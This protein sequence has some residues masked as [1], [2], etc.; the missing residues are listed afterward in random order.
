MANA[1][2]S[3]RV[4]ENVKEQAQE[5]FKSW[6]LDLSTAV[7]MFLCQTI[8]ER[9]I[10]FIIGEGYEVPNAETVAAIEE[11]EDLKKKGYEGYS[12]LE[13]ALKELKD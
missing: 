8:T 13:D 3:I 10:P 6:G 11:L 7:N 4:N 9:R 12:S 2:I 1:T 5:L